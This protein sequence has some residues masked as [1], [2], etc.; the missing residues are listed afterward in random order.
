MVW[1]TLLL[2]LSGVY[3]LTA[4]IR[5]WLFD[6]NI[7]AQEK[8]PVPVICVGN[9]SAGGVGK[10][11]LV[12]FLARQLQA[13][14]KKVAILS[15]GYGRKG[16]GYLVASNGQQRCAEIWDAGDEPSELA[17]ALDG[18]VVVVDEHRVRGANNLIKQFRPDVI[19]LDDGFQHR[20]LAREYNIVVM[21]AREILTGE[22]LLPA[23]NRRESM[24]GLRRAHCVVVSKSKNDA[25]L[26]QA[27]TKLAARF[28]GGIFGA[29][30]ALRSL[31]RASTQQGCDLGTLAGKRTLLFSGIGQPEHFEMTLSP[32]RLVIVRHI[33]FSDHHW[34]SDADIER[35]QRAFAET[36]A[37]L[38][39]TT[40]KD[41][42]RL[43]N[44]R[45]RKFLDEFPVHVAHGQ[46]QF[47]E[48]QSDFLKDLESTVWLSA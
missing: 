38:I 12:E 22:F 31:T 32:L 25:E 40:R 9:I 14:G 21:T 11:P 35:M 17:N 27:R 20:A 45:A 23:G 8:V 1:R 3:W 13:R 41:A 16:K 43:T 5:N 18:V 24:R 7:L 28:K 36:R 33:R 26:Q 15:R 48:G 44:D 34:F 29:K 46:T 4:A 6:K 42:Q 2:P 39:I 19:L 37:E 30:I 10:T 47:A